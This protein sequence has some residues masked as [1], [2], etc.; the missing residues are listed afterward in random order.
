MTQLLRTAAF[1]V[2]GT[3]FQAYSPLGHGKAMK[4][5]A[6]VKIAAD[7]KV[8][9][10]QVALAWIVQQGH[11]LVT[12]SNDMEYDKEDLAVNDLKL[13]DAEIRELNSQRD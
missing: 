10:A 12:S 3:V 5:A 6:V 8:S 2:A 7:H 13:T 4:N 9:A 11:A 1:A